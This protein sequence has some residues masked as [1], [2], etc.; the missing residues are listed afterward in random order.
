MAPN[1]FTELAVSHVATHEGGWRVLFR[2]LSDAK[3]ASPSFIDAQTVV[4]ARRTLG[5]TEILL[6]IS[7]TGGLKLSDGSA[8]A[9]RQW[10]HH[11]LCFGSARTRG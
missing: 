6:T 10:R 5:S 7:R 9:S 8:R 11:R 3:D 4:L 2:A 1:I